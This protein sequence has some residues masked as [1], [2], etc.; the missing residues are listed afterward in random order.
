MLIRPAVP[1]DFPALMR[2]IRAAQ[3]RLKQLGVDQWQNNYP[4]ETTL[5]SDFKNQTGFTAQNGTEIIGYCSL[6][7]QPD[8]DYLLITDGNWES[9][10]PYGVIHRLAVKAET[11]RAGIASALMD[12]A[13]QTARAR[14]VK[15]LRA[16]TH[17][18]NLPM[19]RF[20]D[21]HG[22]TYRGIVYLDGVR[23]RLAFDKEL[24]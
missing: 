24:P 14:G 22:F 2:I 3:E 17:A 10:E 13:G 20:L 16:D 23:K 5:E 21:K 8:K 9:D 19:R 1:A 7:F 11:R 4:N 6:S 15:Y 12:F 18:D